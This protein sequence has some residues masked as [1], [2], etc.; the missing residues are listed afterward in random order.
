MNKTTKLNKW[1]AKLNDKNF[2][3]KGKIKKLENKLLWIDDLSLIWRYKDKIKEL[4]S[5]ILINEQQVRFNLM[6]M[7]NKQ[8]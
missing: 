7:V 8:E 3:M 4:K 2:A 5:K 1:N 6:V